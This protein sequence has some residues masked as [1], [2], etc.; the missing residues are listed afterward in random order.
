[1]KKKLRPTLD[2][3]ILNVKDSYRYF[4]QK[5]H[6]NK[7]IPEFWTYW[8]QKMLTAMTTV[9]SNVLHDYLAEQMKVALKNNEFEKLRAMMYQST[10]LE[11]APTGLACGCDHIRRFYESMN[12]IA[13]L[14]FSS[15]YRCFP[16]GI[17]LSSNGYNGSSL[18]VNLLLCILYNTLEK[19]L[20]DESVIIKRTEKQFLKKGDK[21]IVDTTRC[22][23]GIL[24]HDV[25]MFNIGLKGI[26]T[27][28]NRQDLN[29]SEK[30]LCQYAVGLVVIAKK[31]LSQDEFNSV[32]YPDAKNFSKQYCE[33]IVSKD[34]FEPKT[35][36][37]YHDE[38]S[39]LNQ[40]ALTP[41][42]ITRLHKPYF[43][44]PGYSKKEQNENY[45]DVQRMALEFTMEYRKLFGQEK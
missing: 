25:G 13:S 41:I 9:Y 4:C 33:Y 29:S 36:F 22:L 8:E 6:E 38:L 10:F 43:N 11:N 19:K 5:D 44:K 37:E 34:T 42:P 35:F 39:P 17:P 40:I 21:V 28:Y 7:N 32:E 3:Y 30:V 26:I 23:L 15:V 1:M 14:G 31:F 27:N 2:D 18:N 16:E 20:Y 12:Y 24:K 45:L